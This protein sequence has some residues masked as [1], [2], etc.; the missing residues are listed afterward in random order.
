MRRTFYFQS[1]G[2]SFTQFDKHVLSACYT[3]G[4]VLG[5][6]PTVI[7][8]TWLLSWGALSAVWEADEQRE[9]LHRIVGAV[10]EVSTW[11]L[12]CRRRVLAQPGGGRLEQRDFFEW[13][14]SDLDLDI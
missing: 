6:E 12:A 4:T 2:V 10:V 7:N 11:C 3:V 1:C 9:C 13:R 14:P 8:E 5:A